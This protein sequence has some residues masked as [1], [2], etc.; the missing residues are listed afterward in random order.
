MTR[1]IIWFF[2]FSTTSLYSQ[3]TK[4]KD[5][6][7]IKGNRT[8]ELMGLGLVIGLN[9]TGDTPASISTNR[10]VKKLMS[11]LG[12]ALNDDQ[13]ITQSTAVV[14]VT[15]K[16]PA[17]ARNGDEIDVK[18]SIVGDAT[19][20]AGGT[21]LITPLKAGDGN[22]Y[23]V[24]RGAVVVAQ[25]NGIGAQ[26]LTVATIPNG[27]QV[28]RDFVPSIQKNGYLDF[29]L[30]KS[31]F[32]TANRLSVGINQ[33]FKR[34]L[35]QA[36]DSSLVRVRI[37]DKY[38]SDTVNF[39]SKVEGIKIVVDRKATVVLNERTGTVVMGGDV[40]ISPIVLSH[41]GLSIEV[42]D[43]KPGRDSVMPLDGNTVNGLI[44][45]LNSMGANS[46]DLISILQA[47]HAAGALQADLKYL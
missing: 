21:L 7:N 2:L 34:F 19:S 45:S 11:R 39:I 24:A 22:A 30:K 29:V 18:L 36:V 37:P 44:K 46:S 10:A 8:N 25:A 4:V 1:I 14:V 15:A 20:L 9:A 23:A 5:L 40:K 17:F 26:S 47:I 13:I 3:S 28:E 16:L 31:D 41:N 43:P 38:L 33:A 42:T 32:T 35:A 12:M 6:A 27:G